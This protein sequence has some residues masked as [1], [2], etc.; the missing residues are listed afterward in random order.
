MCSVSLGQL[1]VGNT[2]RR[3]HTRPEHKFKHNNNII[4]IEIKI[5]INILLYFFGYVVWTNSL[6]INLARPHGHHIPFLFIFASYIK[7]LRL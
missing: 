3:E 7:I 2:E 5:E 1:V 4:K 6:G